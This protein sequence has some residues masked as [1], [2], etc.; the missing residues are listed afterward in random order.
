M[1]NLFWLLL[2]AARSGPRYLR[3]ILTLCMELRAGAEM[4]PGTAMTA[5]LAPEMALRAAPVVRT[6]RD[7]TLAGYAG[8]IG[9]QANMVCWI[10]NDV[11]FRWTV[12]LGLEAA[13]VI[14]VGMPAAAVLG[15]GMG[16]I[17]TA[18]PAAPSPMA[19][20]FVLPMGLDATAA[21]ASPVPVAGDFGIPMELD[22]AADTA[23]ATPA[24]AD[25][26]AE[27]P[28]MTA[29]MGVGA[30]VSAGAQGTQ[31]LT[32][33]AKAMCW[34]PPEWV[35]ENTLY[36]RQVYSTTRDGDTLILH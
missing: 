6:A 34:A 1:P 27:L 9:L 19:G 28:G 26:A 10:A 25:L 24:A 11:A 3:A 12:D 16:L 33:T 31:A 35:D 8:E 20:A 13:P 30:P 18:V 32:L 15:L 7:M 4:A 29:R 5:Q 36:I 14:G 17:A 22:A 23:P 21:S 2:A